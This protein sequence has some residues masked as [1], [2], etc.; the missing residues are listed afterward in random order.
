MPS[1]LAVFRLMA[2]PMRSGLMK[3]ATHD[4]RT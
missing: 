2:G 3:A 4:P 1:F